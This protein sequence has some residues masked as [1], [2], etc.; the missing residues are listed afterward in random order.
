MILFYLIG[1]EGNHFYVLAEGQAEAIRD[2]KLLGKITPGKA[3]GE[4][5]IL[6]NCERTASVRGACAVSHRLMIPIW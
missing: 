1:D 6:Y 5:A 4:L 2:D 3:F